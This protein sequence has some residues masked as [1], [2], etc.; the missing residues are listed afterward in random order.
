MSRLIQS[1]SYSLC[2]RMGLEDMGRL[3][4]SFLKLAPENVWLAGQL[5]QSQNHHFR[6]K[7][8]ISVDHKE[9]LADLKYPPHNEATHLERL[10]EGV[11]DPL[12]NSKHLRNPLP[13]VRKKGWLT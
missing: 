12:V 7:K 3:V 11:A 13:A 10:R 6:V 4:Y 1:K 9:S 2:K 5:I 8:S